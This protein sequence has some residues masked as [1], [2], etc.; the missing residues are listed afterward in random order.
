MSRRLFPVLSIIALIVSSLACS[1]PGNSVSSAA[2]APTDS[3]AVT[4]SPSDSATA[5][6]PPAPAVSESGSGA[7]AN[8]FYPIA[9]GVSWSYSFSGA[10]PGNFTRSIIAVNADGFTDQDA[11]DNGVTRTGDWKCDAGALI[12]LQPDGGQSGTS[13]VESSNVSVSFQT[14]EMSGVTMPATLNPGETWTQ[15]FILEGIETINGQEIPAKNETAHSC[16]VGNTESVTVP[17]GT[18]DAVHVD[19]TTDMKITITLNGSEVP[20]AITSTS[21]VWYASGVGMIKTDSQV[22]GA[23]SVIELTAY[24]IP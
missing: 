1:L 20:T 18:F 11:F 21:T 7:C 24:T 17:A 15:N 16:T 3:S 4:S 22:N 12:A 9:V 23:T 8:P 10:A 19:C 6:E 13:N 5:T 2:P 14:T